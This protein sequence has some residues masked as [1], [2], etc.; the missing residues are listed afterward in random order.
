MSSFA[1]F[2][3]LRTYVMDINEKTRVQ[4]GE[5]MEPF[6]LGGR[7]VDGAFRTFEGATP[8]PAFQAPHSRRSV[9]YP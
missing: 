1:T 8:H 2:V 6:T 9:T 4:G 3:F 7:G 5:L